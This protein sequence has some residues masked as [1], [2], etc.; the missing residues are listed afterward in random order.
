MFI[1]EEVNQICD[2]LNEKRNFLQVLVGPRQV[3]KTTAALHIAKQLDCLS[4]YASAD[5]PGIEPSA[6]L[7]F[8][9]DKARAIQKKEKTKVIL[10]LDEVQKIQGWSEIVKKNWDADTQEK[11][12]LHV[13]LLGSAPLLIQ[14][15]LTESLTGR[16]ETNVFRHWLYPEMHQSFGFNLEQYL[17]F[18]GYPGAHGLVG[19]YE[20]WQ[21]YMLDSIIETTISRDVL[22][23]NRIDKPALLRNLFLLGCRYSSR[24]LA[25]Q[26]IVGQLQDA[27]NTTTLAHYLELLTQSWMLTG[28][29]KYSGSVVR[30]RG[31]SPKLQVFNNALLSAQKN[32]D[33]E[34]ARND[35]EYWGQVV[36]SAVGCHLLASKK[37]RGT[38]IR[39]WREGDFEVDFIVASES[40]LYAIEV[41]SG[42]KHKTSGL[43]QFKKKYPKAQTLVVGSGSLTLDEFFRTPL[44]KL[45]FS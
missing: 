34:S 42:R 31:S 37:P 17:F 36:E 40:C 19:D 7:Q 25:Y 5:A 28:L 1:K 32:L 29:Q 22:L 33:F 39:Y 16:F 4:H 35:S 10:I 26:K 24:E 43:L 23:L 13:L 6:W 2:R 21:N 45:L 27:G 18:G 20:R 12:P 3:G 38:L 9:W 11:I 30:Q 15:G 8:E 14:K 44:L 41:Q